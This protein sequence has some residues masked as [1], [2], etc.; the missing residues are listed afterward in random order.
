MKYIGT[1]LIALTL[2]IVSC[3]KDHDGDQDAGCIDRIYVNKNDHEIKS[4]DVPTVDKL[5][6]DNGLDNSDFRY[7]RYLHETR[8]RQYPPYEIWDNK[9]VRV[10][11]YKNNLPV[12]YA[13]MIFAFKNDTYLI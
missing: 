13:D 11:Q 8:Q 12:F 3:K 1:F 6:A 5:F 10:D 4:A 9:V 2:L 7:I